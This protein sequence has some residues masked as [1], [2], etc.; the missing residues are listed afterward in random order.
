MIEYNWISLQL[1]CYFMYYAEDWV[2]Y[3]EL[4]NFYSTDIMYLYLTCSISYDTTVL[5]FMECK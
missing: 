4:F 1:N 5:G 2:L 3:Y